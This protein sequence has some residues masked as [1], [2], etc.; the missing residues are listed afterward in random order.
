MLWL[1]DNRSDL[2][3]RSDVHATGLFTA[4]LF[5]TDLRAAH[6]D[7]TTDVQLRADFFA[8]PRPTIDADFFCIEHEP[9]K[10]DVSHVGIIAA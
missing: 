5:T 8:H 6:D 1:S 9:N 10:H 3:L 2:R 4:G 7:R